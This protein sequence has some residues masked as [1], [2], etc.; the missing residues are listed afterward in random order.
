MAPDFEPLR[1]RRNDQVRL[2]RLSV[3]MISAA[4]TL[5]TIQDFVQEPFRRIGQSAFD[6]EVIR[7]SWNGLCFADRALR[8]STSRNYSFTIIIVLLIFPDASMQT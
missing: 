1:H 5:Y 2:H 6:E 3:C 8:L 4:P 7:W